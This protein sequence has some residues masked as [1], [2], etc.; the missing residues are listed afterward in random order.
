MCPRE[1]AGVRV[2]FGGRNDNAGWALAEQGQSIE[3]MVQIREGLAAYRATG[4]EADRAYFLAL[5]AEAYGRG[6]RNDE[7]LAVLEE[8][9][10]LMDHTHPLSGKLNSIGSRGR[11]CLHILQAAWSDPPPHSSWEDH[12]VPR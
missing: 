2:P 7:G 5:L 6:K 11:Y 4:A 10:A 8:A 3:G 1:G 9:L 12:P